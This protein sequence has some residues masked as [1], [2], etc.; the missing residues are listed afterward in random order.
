M[1][2]KISNEI[3]VGV[4]A[5]L[6]ILAFIY[7]YNYLKGKD[8][9]SSM[10]SYYVIYKDISG[11]TESNPVEINGYK[12]GVVQSIFLINDNSGRLLVELSIKK[13]YKLP[14]GSYAEIT[15]A[16]LIA[17][18]KV[19]IIFGEG[20]GVY[21]NGDTIPG[22]LS[23]PILSIFE[24]E[25][26]PVKN[27]INDLL[28]VLDST[29]SG[30]NTLVNSQDLKRS[31]SNLSSTT[32][33]INEIVSTQKDDIKSAIKD[34]SDF[35]EMLS[36]NATK[37]EKTIQNLQTI[38]D[39]M[40]SSG[41]TESFSELKITLEETRRLLEGIN[42][43]KGTAGQ[44]ITNDTLY[45]NLSASLESLDRLLRDMK[46]NPKKYVHFSIFGRK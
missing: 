23:E 39:S 3:K 42:E 32:G 43:G 4:A 11:L 37:I 15:S 1:K 31:I 38:T 16:S 40:A 7:L 26:I 29:I 22:R 24:K 44:L 18:M 19:R 8:L 20:I 34:F 27:K 9:F 36:S 2:I 14:Q 6:T 35:S 25:F 30:I 12:V 45:R 10:A 28:Y 33:N 46:D 21:N 5:I 41:L 13:S 17:G